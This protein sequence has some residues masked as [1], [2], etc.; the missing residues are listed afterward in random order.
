MSCNHEIN[1]IS[2]SEAFQEA[3]SEKDSGNASNGMISAAT[4]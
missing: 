1:T 4:R 2:I 3:L